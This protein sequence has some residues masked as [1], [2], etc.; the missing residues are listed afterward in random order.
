MKLNQLINEVDVGDLQLA[1]QHSR[2]PNAAPSPTAGVWLVDKRTARR[3]AGP[4]A[5]VERARA[6][7][8]N[9]PDKIPADAVVRQYS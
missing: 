6:H 7:Q 4:F 9:R 1:A 2:E 8:K 5:S 3:L